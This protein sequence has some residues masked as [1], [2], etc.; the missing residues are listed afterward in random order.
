MIFHENRLLA[1]KSH[2]ISYLIFFW[3]L[4]KMSQN[5]SSA[6]VV[7]GAL[8]VKTS[9][10]KTKHKIFLLYLHENR[11]KCPNDMPPTNTWT[12]LCLHEEI[13]ELLIL[14]LLP[15]YLALKVCMLETNCL[16]ISTA[17]YWFS[18]QQNP[19]DVRWHKHFLI[20]QIHYHFMDQSNTGLFLSAGPCHTKLYHRS[21]LW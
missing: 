17:L 5:L 18:R 9:S 6:A 19:F 13:R 15:P 16:Q 4:G 1:D 10:T 3:K 11:F 20:H 2:E 12:T 8:R 21:R 14:S 7:I